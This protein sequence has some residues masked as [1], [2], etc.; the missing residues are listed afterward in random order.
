M[1]KP[2]PHRDP[3][4]GKPTDS[5]GGGKAH[6]SGYGHIGNHISGKIERASR[7]NG[8]AGKA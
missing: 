2:I 1:A 8:R 5:I 7:N 6:P 4:T 3:I